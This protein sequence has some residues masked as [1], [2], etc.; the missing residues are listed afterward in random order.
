[1]KC[2]HTVGCVSDDILMRRCPRLL[3]MWR[4]RRKSRFISRHATM[5]WSVNITATMLGWE[6]NR[7]ATTVKARFQ[8]IKEKGRIGAIRRRMSGTWTVALTSRNRTQLHTTQHI[9]INAIYRGC[10]C[11]GWH[12][13]VDCCLCCGFCLCLTRHCRCLGNTFQLTGGQNE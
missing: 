9:H 6:T 3:R 4:H 7:D 5:D 8:G 12:W 1:M 10:E 13:R 11:C 2:A